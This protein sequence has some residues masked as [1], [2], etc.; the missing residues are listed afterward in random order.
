M[1]SQAGLV[2]NGAED[3]T[4]EIS[5]GIWAG[6]RG[7]QRLLKLFEKNNMTA[8]WSILEHS[9]ETFPKDCAAVRDTGH[10]IG[11]HGLQP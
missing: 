11:L 7:T 6:T 10:E 8:K 1:L 5:R 3:S 9:L 2:R 4:T